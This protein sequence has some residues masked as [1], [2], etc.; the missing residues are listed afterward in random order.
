MATNNI[1][2]Y[3]NY[4][5]PS[6]VASVRE[7]IEKNQRFL[8]S[9]HIH[10]DGDAIGSELCLYHLLKNMKKQV[11]I[12]NHSPIPELYR[13]LDPDGL[14]Q[15]FDEQ[16][17]GDILNRADVCFLLDIGDWE[18][19]DSVGKAIHRLRQQSPGKL[20]TV[21]IDHHP[22]EKQIADFDIIY[23]RASS[24]GEILFLLQQALSI[25]F[26]L[27][28]ASALYTA[29]V[30]DTGSFRFSNTTVNSH[31]IAGRLLALGVNH[32]D[33]YQ[34]VYEKEPLSKIKLL[35]ELLNNLHFECD[36]KVVWYVISKEML[37]RYQL[38]L[39][40]IEGV[41][42]FP[43]RIDGVQVSVLFTEIDASSTK[44]S[45][46]SKGKIS[47][48]GFAQTFGGGGHPYASGAVVEKPIEQA[49]EQVISQFCAYY[50]QNTH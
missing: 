8:L 47:I 48:N 31:L 21:C 19:L 33:I 29:I 43:R 12:L 13:F 23:P 17:H 5:Q 49:I 50:Y 26:N 15:V 41:S 44:I 28:S 14:I 32:K 27:Q 24:T 42:D 2:D 18:R 46:R 22:S 38:E 34:Q 30:T 10:P 35:A 7:V 25:P 16:K 45:L 4:L 40:E 6:G 11:H 37:Q 20:Q 39:D 1:N 36:Q 3:E 9:T